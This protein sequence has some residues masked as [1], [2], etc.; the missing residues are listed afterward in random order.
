MSDESIRITEEDIIRTRKEQGLELSDEEKEQYRTRVL[1]VLK[2]IK[3]QLNLIYPDK[4]ELHI[5]NS[6]KLFSVT[7]IIKNK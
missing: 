6:P 2:N 1:A 7:I 5:D 3:K 4:F